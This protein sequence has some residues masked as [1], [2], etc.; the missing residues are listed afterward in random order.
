MYA[1]GDVAWRFRASVKGMNQGVWVGLVVRGEDTSVMLKDEGMK[2][3]SLWNDKKGYKK[4]RRNNLECWLVIDIFR[5]DIMPA[6]RLWIAELI[7]IIYIYICSICSLIFGLVGRDSGINCSV[8]QF[9]RCSLSVVSHH[10]WSVAIL[11]RYIG[12]SSQNKKLLLALLERAWVAR[13][14]G[15]SRQ[16]RSRLR[17]LEPRL[18]RSRQQYCS[19][20][21]WDQDAGVPGTN[22]GEW[23]SPGGHLG[24]SGR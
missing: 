17:R 6:S 3:W 12:S 13:S 21:L 15:W 22:L 16:Q 9:T 7:Y 5:F 11:A 10:I 19:Q 20:P 23:R 24:H 2:G 4:F 8:V 14:D 1:L 18:A